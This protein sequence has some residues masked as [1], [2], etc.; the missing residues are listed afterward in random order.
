[1]ALIAEYAWA[2]IRTTMDD[3]VS[4]MGG[5]YLVSIST[6]LMGYAKHK[7]HFNVSSSHFLAGLVY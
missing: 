6:F 4:G 5:E 7:L 2:E 3:V 1:M